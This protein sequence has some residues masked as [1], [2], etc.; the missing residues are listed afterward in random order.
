M[1]VNHDGKVTIC[2]ELDNSGI[3][4][5]VGKVAGEFGG[6]EKTVKET[7]KAIDRAFTQTGKDVKITGFQYDTKEIERFV[8]EYAAG[9]NKVEHHSNEMKQAFE[10]ARQKVE[11]LEEQGFWWGD[12]EYE[13]AFAALDRIK[14]DI[15]EA[16]HYATTPPEV[17]NPFGIDTLAG[18][19]QEAKNQ[20]STLSA[21]GK[22]L[23]NEEYD[24]AYAALARLTQEAKEYKRALADTTI[25]PGIDTYEGKIQSL[26]VELAKLRA[27]GKG[28]GD[29]AY[30]ELYRKLAL[31]KGEAKEYAAHL[32]KGPTWTRKAV[33]ET[34]KLKKKASEANK[35][36]GAMG[37]S[38][39]SFASRLKSIAL[40]ALVFN[41]IS[42]G[43]REV[44]DYMG[45]ALKKNEAFTAEV[46]RL[47]GALLTAFQPIYTAVAPAVIYL[48]RILTSATLVIAEF[49]AMLTGTNVK[50]NAAAAENLYNEADAIDKVGK[51]AKK[52]SKSV[53]GFDELNIIQ[54]KA[55]TSGASAT[56]GGGDTVAPNFDV[57]EMEP[58]DLSRITEFAK[59]LGVVL[60]LFGNLKFGGALLAVTGVIEIINGIKDIVENGLNWENAKQVITGIADIGTGIGFM[61]GNLK[62]A[63]I[64]MTI[65]GLTTVITEIGK[66]WEAIKKGDWS[67][68]DKVTLATGAIQS[69]GGLLFALDVFSKLKKNTKTA[70]AAKGV[71]ETSKEVSEL[72]GKLKDLVKNLALGIVIIAEVAVA[73]GLVIAAIWGIGVLL[74]QVGIAWQPVI[75]NGE[76]IATAIGIGTLL[77]VGIGLATAAL[78]TL[79]G[80][81]CGQIGIGIAILAELGV[82]TGLFLAEIWAVG[83]G[84][85]EINKAW[86]PVL[87]NGEEIAT[88]IGVGTGLLVGIGV[89]TAAL[90][91]A[92]V[93]SA[94]LLPLAIGL[95]TALLVEL[96]LAFIAFCDSL[97]EVAK[98]LIALSAPME[99]LNA[100]LPG[101]K[102]DMDNF[103]SFM[104]DFASA[105]VKFSEASVI[106]GIAATI[107]KVI[108]FFTT[109]PV[110]RMYEEVEDQTKEFKNLIPAL[111]KINPM[112]KKATK[113][114]GEY[115]ENM[116]SFESATGGS[117]G[118]LNSI[119][120]GAKGAVNGLIRLFEGMANGVIKCINAII[121]GLNKISFDVPNWVP[122][123]GGKTFGFKIK[124]IPEV[125]IPRLAQG[126]VIPPNKEFLAVL[127]DQ[128]HG[129]NVEAPLATIQEAVAVVMQDYAAS[130]LAGHEA[131]VAVLREILEAV[132]GISIG[133]DMI[134]NAVNRY[135][136]K[137][138]IVKGVHV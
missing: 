95:G 93:A 1:G 17:D 42:A 88:A 109:D 47:K 97:I 134:A 68:V 131:T 33:C 2:T 25:P 53:S 75:D 29:P 130:N 30:D 91:V 21:A 40:G 136:A 79:G 15:A 127:G 23:G 48:I 28:L 34:E 52:A 19:I 16:E 41:G 137:M 36:F 132:L 60:A 26:E 135:Q 38:V 24:E 138:A 122:E 5:S 18:K 112:I 11:N 89:V 64:S 78:G 50:T 128:R 116:G 39:N 46:A 44:A 113:L 99:E 62:L 111:E 106:A 58:V 126:A 10:E 22:G 74:E 12:E 3:E 103:T 76:T 35:Q 94:G 117:G 83:K 69:I 37:K 121:K 86:K 123:I 6:L 119:V 105:V 73:V 45:N 129:T 81:M 20:L 65:S 125:S 80:A 27:M 54:N 108:D 124:N 67:G 51:A 4:K 43:L 63:G 13:A 56:S 61:F 85:N 118:F 9:F 87:D 55:D 104:S 31:I 77:L 110:Q 96:A 71:S 100:I 57:E 82:A 107:D 72:T 49:F 101:L 120:S 70:D 102:T 14:K 66:N 59:G 133:D 114:V 115:K 98:K 92:T 8:N 90:G 7:E 32:A 84:L